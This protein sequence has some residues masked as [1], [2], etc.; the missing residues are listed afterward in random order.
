MLR[1]RAARPA[2]VELATD[3]PG[4][5]GDP[6]GVALDRE[7]LA[8]LVADLRALPDRQREA[9]LAGVLAAPATARR[10][11]RR[12]ML[13]FAR[14]NLR[15]LALAREMPCHE[16]RAALA[17][18]AERGVRP[19]ELVRRHVLSCPACQAHRAERGRG[20]VRAAAG[21]D[22]WLGSELGAAKVLAVVAITSGT[23]PVIAPHVCGSDPPV[24][25]RARHVVKKSTARRR[26]RRA[27]R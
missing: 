12:K 2:T 26:R 13:L 21:L 27:S 6:A 5:G 25:P 11:A 8:E 9:L 16:V 10:A 7:R 1:A 20:A 3:L 17:A 19:S 18:S 15:V 4:G 24:A 23:V 14:R 22:R